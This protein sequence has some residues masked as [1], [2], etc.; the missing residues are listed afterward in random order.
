MDLSR[1]DGTDFDWEESVTLDGNEASV[2]RCSSPWLGLQRETDRQ[3][4]MI[5]SNLHEAQ[6]DSGFKRCE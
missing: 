4:F 3:V 5:I 6:M 1:Y 2:P